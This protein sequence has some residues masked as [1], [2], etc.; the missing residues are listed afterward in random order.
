MPISHTLPGKSHIQ[1]IHSKDN[2]SDYFEQWLY[3]WM[4][5]FFFIKKVQFTVVLF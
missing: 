5:F 3:F 2:E 4:C 1:L